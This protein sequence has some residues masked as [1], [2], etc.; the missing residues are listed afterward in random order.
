M[1]TIKP[2]PTAKV[3]KP[4]KTPLVHPDDQFI[5]IRHLC[6]PLDPASV[7]ALR[8]RLGIGFYVAGFPVNSDYLSDTVL[9]TLGIPQKKAKK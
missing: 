5:E 2:K 8:C 1:K 3:R 7:E 9:C 6:I 4:F